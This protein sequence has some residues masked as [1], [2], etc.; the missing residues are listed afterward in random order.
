MYIHVHIRYIFTYVS[1][2]VHWSRGYTL[3]F[4]HT[5]WYMTYRMYLCTNNAAVLPL[6][7]LLDFSPKCPRKHVRFFKF[8]AS[9]MSAHNSH[10]NP[11]LTDL[12]Q[13]TMCYAYW[14]AGRHLLP[15]TFDVFFRKNPFHGEYTLFAGLDDVLHY[16]DTWHMTAD[17]LHFLQTQVLPHA[18]P[19]FF[20]YLQHLDCSQVSV[21]AVAEGSVVFP[22]E[23]LLRIDGPL[24]ICQLLETTILNLTNF[25]SLVT[26]NAARFRRAA[27]P[28]AVLLEF[29]LRRAQGPDGAMTASRYCYMGGFDGTSNVLAAKMYGVPVKGTHA[30][31]FVCS[32]SSLS[33]LNSTVLPRAKGVEGVEG[34]GEEDFVAAVLA[35]RER[36]Q[37]TST[38]DGELAAFISY[39][40]AFPENFLALVDTYDTLH[41]GVRNFL[42]VAYCLHR[43]G[44]TP[45]GVRLDSGDLAWLSLECRA[46]FLRF[47]T[48]MGVEEV[49]KSL[50]IVASNDINE[51][52]L[53]SLADQGHE[54]NAFGIGTN[55]VTCQAQPALGMV[56]KLVEINGLPR[57]K[58]SNEV[59]KMTI[60]GRKNVYRL[61]G[62]EGMPLLDLICLCSEP[63]P[64][65]GEKVLCCSPFDEK[66]RVYVTPTVV[67]PMLSCWRGGERGGAR[68]G[69]R[70]GDTGGTGDT[71]GHW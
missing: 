21:H 60:P 29:G 25:A 31:A 3:Y 11:L 19:A 68:G 39:A 53:L 26:T 24:G 38:N 57:I 48:E 14:K 50:I 22:R 67:Q 58:L 6:M 13:L 44:Y 16:L 64:V 63:A 37:W 20:E 27:G 2:I 7:W 61:V 46:A 62:K 34:V 17:D 49:F 5:I 40:Q 54:I 8:L 56:F 66:K 10:I 52:V 33:D 69:E 70:G 42:V 12:Y 15:S 45:V 36:W 59:V 18:E 51:T 23:P 30:H 35:L 47:A 28:D 43:R 32:Y 65:A 4:T 1:N 71:G 55:L 41:S 9:T